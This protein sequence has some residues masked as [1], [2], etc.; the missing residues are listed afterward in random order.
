MRSRQPSV[1][2]RNWR[3]GR[4]SR[5]SFATTTIGPSGT[6]SSR[7]AQ[8]AP[9][10]RRACSA[11]SGA[12]ASTNHTSAASAAP[13]APSTRSASAIIVPRPGPSSTRRKPGRPIA[14]QTAATQ[15]PIIS[16]NIWLISGAVTK[17]PPAPSG[18]R[19]A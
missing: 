6:S 13:A 3:T 19:V 10:T 8:R 9:G 11:R 5:N 4:A 15:A 17:S 2:F 12:E 16:P 7:A 18:S 14:C 1:D